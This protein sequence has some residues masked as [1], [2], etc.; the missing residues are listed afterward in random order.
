M[1]LTN[2]RGIELEN[3]LKGL[4]PVGYSM[5]ANPDDLLDGRDRILATAHQREAHAVFFFVSFQQVEDVEQMDDLCAKFKA[6]KN[7]G[8][9]PMVM[10]ARVDEDEASIRDDTF[11]WKLPKIAKYRSELARKLNV[12]VANVLVSVPYVTRDSLE[13]DF[14][15]EKLAYHNLKCALDAAS[16]YL[17]AKEAGSRRGI[18]FEEEDE[19]DEEE[20]Y[21][22]VSRSYGSARG[23]RGGGRDWDTASQSSV[24]S[25]SYVPPYGRSHSGAGLGGRGAT[26]GPT[27]PEARPG[28]R[29]TSPLGRDGQ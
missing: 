13:R 24:G 10:L 28:L 2:Y 19:E 3:M 25:A 11:N 26:T 12:G 29:F 23:G 4:L 21:E 6:V 27:M 9:N 5:D 17:L 14:Q 22:G 15:I 7:L 16:Q 1:E 18:R 8:F 20:E